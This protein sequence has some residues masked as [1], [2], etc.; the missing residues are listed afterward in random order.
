MGR[1]ML[2]ESLDQHRGGI[3]L[4]MVLCPLKGWEPIVDAKPGVDP[5]VAVAGTR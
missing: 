5:G 2:E 1:A 3:Y 4:A